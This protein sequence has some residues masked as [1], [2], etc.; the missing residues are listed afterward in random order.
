LEKELLPRHVDIVLH[1]IGPLKALSGTNVLLD[2]V[3]D[4]EAR[5]FVF[6]LAL[7][8]APTC[9]WQVSIRP[10]GQV[11][12]LQDGVEIV[13]LPEAT[14]DPKKR[15]IHAANALSEYLNLP[16]NA[17]ANHVSEVPSRLPDWWPP[18]FVVPSNSIC[19][20]IGLRPVGA[21][22]RNWFNPV[23]P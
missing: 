23:R 17:V 21:R 6:D 16:E 10:E 19:V 22:P 14:R 18:S 7:L 4:V 8:L 15:L 12:L 9:K 13:Y 1:A 2:S 5:R 3:N 20:F 11:S